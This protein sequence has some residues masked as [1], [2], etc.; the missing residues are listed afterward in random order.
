M[1]E[2]RSPAQGKALNVL[3][4]VEPHPIRNS[5]T[6]HAEPTRQIGPVLARLA[7]A[8]QIRL[9]M[10]CNT[11]VAEQCRAEKAS[12]APYLHE[13]TAA[14]SDRIARSFLRWNEA[15]IG[16]WLS[17]V[18]GK[19][20]VAAFYR[21]ILERL[22][23]E[24]PID[25]ILLWSENGAARSFAAEQGIGLLHAELGPT[26]LP[27]PPTF[28]FD[29]G[30]T[31]GHAALR[32]HVRR[33]LEA[34]DPAP[35]VAAQSWLARS[36]RQHEDETGTPSL[37]DLPLTY[38]PDTIGLLPSDPYVYIPLQLADDLNTL[39]HSSF[40]SPL[41]F[42]D[43]T[44]R[45]VSDLGYTAVI[46][47]HPGA[48]SRPHNLRREVEALEHVA[49]H[50]PEAVI[51]P[52]DTEGALAVHAL[53]R[54]CYTV[55]INS[56]VGFES[57]M[58]GVPTILRGEAIYDA[59]GW[60]QEQISIAPPAARPDCS[61]VIDRLL[62]AHLR[63]A[64]VPQ[65]LAQTTD[66]LLH[67]LRDAAQGGDASPGMPD[68]RPWY[69]TGADCHG[70]R[71]LDPEGAGAR[72]GARRLDAADRPR[73]GDQVRIEGTEVV[74]SGP[75]EI[76]LRQQGGDFFGSLDRSETDEEGLRV[77]EGWCLDRQTM[78]PPLAILSLAGDRVHMPAEDSGSRPDVRAAHPGA[79]R[80]EQAGFRI[81]LPA[82]GPAR[83]LVFTADGR[84]GLI[85]DLAPPSGL[86]CRPVRSLA[87]GRGVPAA[88]GNR[89]SKLLGRT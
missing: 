29:T 72:D 36:E 53:A 88:L 31:N 6:E 2:A 84:C 18:R 27:F 86:A 51:L 28:Y 32:G 69:L 77:L 19:G 15:M 75:S 80:A 12:Y 48:A 42:L 7:E 30:G 57:M 71:V 81:A 79:R 43:D 82:E 83:L 87:S 65:A 49:R 13:P 68:F 37:L 25:V 16:E 39:L 54:A 8:G 46:K 59:G 10:F 17:L 1:T 47:G 85:S 35:P 50:W 4:W 62:A 44:M 14:E 40:E 70:L 76:R 22:H 61:A 20:E 58:L 55:T 60:L 63:D 21:G 38:R 52:P 41:G 3:Y 78:A 24:D 5:F 66:Y 74:V 9:R 33:R 64:F 56:S 34:P 23:A 11:P 45:M 73:T 89:L 67:R 26:R